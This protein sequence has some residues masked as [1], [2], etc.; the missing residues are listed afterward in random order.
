[1]KMNL[2]ISESKSSTYTQCLFHCCDCHCLPLALLQR[3]LRCRL[4]Q[5]T[6]QP[7]LPPAPARRALL[8]STRSMHRLLAAVPEFVHAFLHS[9][10][11]GLVV[12]D[13]ALYLA[14]QLAHPACDMETTTLKRNAHV[15]CARLP[16]LRA[17]VKDSIAAVRAADCG[18]L[19]AVCDMR[20]SAPMLER[21]DEHPR[22]LPRCSRAPRP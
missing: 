21:T 10:A 22:Q 20:S 9:P 3:G 16:T 6:T 15:R 12:L 1:M 4:T 14:Q 17:F 11:A 8:V 5:P 18:K 13:D 2:Y 7:L 19:A